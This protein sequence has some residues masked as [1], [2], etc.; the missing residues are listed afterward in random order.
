[1]KRPRF[2]LRT[3]L[4]AVL[5]VA[6]ACTVA[7]PL[8]RW[9]FPPP[10]SDFDRMVREITETMEKANNGKPFAKVEFEYGQS[11]VATPAPSPQPLRGEEPKR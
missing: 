7:P 4:I 2:S 6:I 8:Y 1:M 10:E 9:M 5:L 3:L 11:A